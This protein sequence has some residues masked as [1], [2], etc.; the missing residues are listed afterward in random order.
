[1]GIVTYRFFFF[2]PKSIN[3][4]NIFIYGKL[5]TLNIIKI[6]WKVQIQPTL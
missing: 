6:L 3:Q 1:M 2:F 5:A 4:I